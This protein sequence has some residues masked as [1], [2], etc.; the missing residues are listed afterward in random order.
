LRQRD[1]G[2]RAPD[3]LDEAIGQHHRAVLDPRRSPS[4]TVAPRIAV[5]E[6]G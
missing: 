6:P 1:R 3:R 4:N 2:V 5:S